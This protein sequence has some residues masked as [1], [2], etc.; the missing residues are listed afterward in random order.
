VHPSA[1]VSDGQRLY[2]ANRGPGTVAVFG[3]DQLGE[4]RLVTI[5][6][7]PCGGT[8]PRDLTATGGHLWVANPDEDLLSVFTL[9]PGHRPEPAFALAAPTPTC[10][11]QPPWTGR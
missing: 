6:E 5:G 1:L 3:L 4:D 11:V 7:F 9:A 10:V 8:A 2:V